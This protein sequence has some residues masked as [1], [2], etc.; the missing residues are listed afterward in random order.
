M[1]AKT[2]LAR[3]KAQEM[4]EQNGVIAMEKHAAEKAL[5]VAL[6]A[7][8]TAR[9]A[10]QNF[11]K[12]DVTEIRSVQG[13]NQNVKGVWDIPC[14]L[15]SSR[16]HLCLYYLQINSNFAIT[17]KQHYSAK[18]LYHLTSCRISKMTKYLLDR[19][20]RYNHLLF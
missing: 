20:T 8:V 17:A 14:C 11:E 15:P 2:A 3:R 18:Y 16:N 7:L 5:S 9:L 13:F 19:K 10:L 12:S 6:P 4:E 1:D